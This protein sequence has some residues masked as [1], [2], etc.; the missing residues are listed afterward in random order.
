MWFGASVGEGGDGRGRGGE[1]GEE[2]GA[3][4]QEG[5]G[6]APTWLQSDGDSL[7]EKILS[8]QFVNE[9]Q[10][11]V[12][13]PALLCSSKPQL[14]PTL[15][16]TLTIG[17]SYLCSSSFFLF[18]EK[19]SS[20]QNFSHKVKHLS[21]SLSISTRQLFAQNASNVNSSNRIYLISPFACF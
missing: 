6:Q 8:L 3:H 19:V 17:T 13:F 10:T 9:A 21:L 12:T 11:S 1:V 20:K 4:D 5:P 7:K 16:K 18:I 2:G 15:E 14:T